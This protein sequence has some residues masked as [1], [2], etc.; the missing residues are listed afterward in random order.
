[1]TYKPVLSIRVDERTQLR[2]LESRHA[3]VYF[4]VVERNRDYLYEW[5][6]VKAYEG[7]LETLRDFIKRML[8][9]FVNG[10]GYHLGIWYEEE[11]IGTIDYA[12]LDWR[13]RK[14]ELGFWIDAAMQRKGIMTKV[15]QTLIRHAFEELELNKVEITCATG[16]QRSRAMAERLGF[17]LEGIHRQGD[18]QHD[19]YDDVAYYGLLVDEWKSRNIIR[20]GTL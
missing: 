12:N 4:A 10:Q 14:V 20:D 7:S 9:N 5:T 6:D 1:M 16:N 17:A 8:L 13:S 19:H 11:L 15:C 18:W 3:E 2:L